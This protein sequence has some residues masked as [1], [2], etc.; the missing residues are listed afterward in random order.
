MTESAPPTHPIVELTDADLAGMLTRAVRV[1]LVLGALIA[2]ILWPTM[3]WG[4]AALF[5]VGA[6]ISVA[7]IFEWGRLI[8]LFNAKLDQQKTPRGS[9]LVVTL[10]LLRLIL[11]AGAIYGSLKCSHGSPIA[12]LCGLALA[13]AGL[14]WEAVRLLRV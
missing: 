1:T 14:V 13:L 10:F 11:F 7:S 6:A 3:G 4:T 8:R 12:L 9:W 5:A 2:L